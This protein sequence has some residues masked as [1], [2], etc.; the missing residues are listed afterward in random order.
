MARRR[1]TPE[2]IIRKLREADRMLG[3]G[4][5]R[6]HSRSHVGNDNLFSEANFKTLK[7][8]P[9]FP[10]RFGSIEDAQAFCAAFFNYCRL[11][12]LQ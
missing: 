2:Q 6:S 8:C 5:A 10:G 3:E 12:A 1:H 4:V 7:Y 11:F 9:A